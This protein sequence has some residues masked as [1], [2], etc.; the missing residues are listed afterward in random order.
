[1]RW[2]RCVLSLPLYCQQ[3]LGLR[4]QTQHFILKN[5][6]QG[7]IIIQLSGLK[8]GPLEFQIA[9]VLLDYLIQDLLILLYNQVNNMSVLRC[10]V[11]I[12]V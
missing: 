10:L 4:D 7:T 11:L 9:R 12:S 8:L 1:M 5:F 2:S 6:L 3:W